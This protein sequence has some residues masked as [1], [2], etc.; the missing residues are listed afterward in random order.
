MFPLIPTMWL[1]LSPQ[2]SI[3]IAAVAVCLLNMNTV[4][5]HPNKNNIDV[6]PACFVLS[7]LSIAW[8]NWWIIGSLYFLYAK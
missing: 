1:M 8:T 7:F 4:V 5:V 2:A 3:S 6:S